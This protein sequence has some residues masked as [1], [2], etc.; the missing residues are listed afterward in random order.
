MMCKSMELC[1]GP[2]SLLLTCRCFAC[3]NLY[4]IC[5]WDFYIRYTPC[6]PYYHT[7]ILSIVPCH[8][9]NMQVV[10]TIHPAS[11]SFVASSGIS[12]LLNCTCTLS[13]AHCFMSQC[14]LKKATGCCTLAVLHAPCSTTAVCPP[15]F[16]SV[17]HSRTLVDNISCYTR[18]STSQNT[19]GHM[20]Y[21]R[22]NCQQIR[23]LHRSNVDITSLAYVHAA[24]WCLLSISEI[25]VPV[26]THTPTASFKHNRISIIY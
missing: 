16:C 2:L 21:R 13:L 12:Q 3:Q 5:Y 4:L 14:N 20:I 25:H 17:I 26:C 19:Q 6:L 18:Q 24:F 7:T 1:T 23:T 22:Y 8:R 10:I 11:I 9:C 15:Q